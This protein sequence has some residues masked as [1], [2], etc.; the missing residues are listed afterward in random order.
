VRKEKI[1]IYS[2]PIILDRV[3]A[4][5]DYID[6]FKNLLKNINKLVL[7]DQQG[8]SVINLANINLILDIFLKVVKSKACRDAI[9][10][11][12]ELDEKFIESL[13]YNLGKCSNP[14][15]CAHGRH[16]FFILAE[17]N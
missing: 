16:N 6:I 14:F 4:K 9:K 5:E 7:V 10:F 11:N 2:V 1:I 15:L 13:I 17:K 8:N 12:E 3:L